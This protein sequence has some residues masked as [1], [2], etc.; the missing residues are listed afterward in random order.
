M[1]SFSEPGAATVEAGFRTVSPGTTVA[2]WESAESSSVRMY[3][4]AEAAKPTSVRIAGAAGLLLPETCPVDV[5][6]DFPADQF[7]I[8]AFVVHGATGVVIQWNSRRGQEAADRAL[9]LGILESLRFGI[10]G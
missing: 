7:F 3:A 1:D 10:S 2:E 6:G 5:V 8:N 9:F 4:C